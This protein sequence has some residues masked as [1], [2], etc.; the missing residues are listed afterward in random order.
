MPQQLLVSVN[1]AA[2]RSLVH[3]TPARRGRVPAKNYSSRAKS[4]PNSSSF[5][6]RPSNTSGPPTSTMRPMSPPPS[7]PNGCA[8]ASRAPSKLSAPNS[9]AGNPTPSTGATP[10]SNSSKLFSR[11][12][13]PPSAPSNGPS[14]TSRTSRKPHPAITATYAPSTGS[15]ATSSISK[16]SPTN[17]APAS[18]STPMNSHNRPKAKRGAAVS[19]FRATHHHHARANRTSRVVR[20]RKGDIA[21]L[22]QPLLQ[23]QHHMSQR[24]PLFA[25]LNATMLVPTAPRELSK[26]KGGHCGVASTI[27]A[28]SASHVAAV[29][30]FRA[31]HHHHARAN[32]TAR[33]VRKRKGDIAGLRQPLPHTQHHMQQRCPLFA[34]L[35]A[36]ILQPSDPPNPRFPITNLQNIP[37]L[38]YLP[39]RQQL[40]PLFPRRQ[41]TR[42]LINSL[43]PLLPM[44]SK[45]L[46]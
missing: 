33:V 43:L 4:L 26:A 19:P 32:R 35:I 22:R 11:M 17:A 41:T 16:P 44:A 46:P 12:I 5:S 20:K 29:S 14:R 42:V 30:P 9:S 28:N 31:T 23:T 1:R 34:L 36:T 39:S 8:S 6:R 10:K 21:G 40:P 38:F 24:C 3:K 18:P 27:T 7:A 2:E 25:L 37:K 13:A 45:G 15:T